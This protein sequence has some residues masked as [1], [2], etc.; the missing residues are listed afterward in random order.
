MTNRQGFLSAGTGRRCTN[1]PA[2]IAHGSWGAQKHE[3]AEGIDIDLWVTALALSDTA[4]TALLLDVDV[5][6]LTGEAATRLRSAVSAATG[7]PVAN[8]RASATH[9]H[10]GPVPYKSWIEKGFDL[11]GPWFERLSQLS[12]EAASEAMANLQPAQVRSGRGEC[13]ININRRAHTAEGRPILGK[14]RDGFSDHEV[15]VVKLDAAGGGTIATLVHYACHPTIMGPANRLITPDYPGVVKRVVEEAVGGRCLFL[16]G[17]AGDQGPVQGFQ[18]DVRVYRGLG[19]I[20]GHEAAKVALGLNYLP[21]SETL[22]EVVESGA[23]LG[24]Y[25]EAFPALS[26]LP[27]QVVDREILVPLRGDLP[28]VEA[29]TETLRFWKEKL[30]AARENQ[31]EEA[32]GEATFMA[33]RADL[34]LRLAQDFRGRTD[35]GVNTQFICFGD[36]A[37]VSCNVE[38]FA[39]IG[40]AI[41]SRSPFPVTL[42]SGYSNGRLA[43]LPTAREWAN[44]GYEV[45]NSPFGQGAAHALQREVVETLQGVRAHQTGK[46]R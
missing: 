27:L 1:P 32:I 26:S 21:A 15:L 29:A 6:I 33:R 30:Q 41:K 37:L 35:V 23:P 38:P 9:T 11:V 31:E 8:I 12:A 25:E 14:N 24:M 19:A 20:L 17:A 16:Q 39:E 40:A 22:R 18:A 45:E 36:V 42:F 10:S 13:S 7:V 2:G 44:G 43:Y 5:Q 3:Q 46:S 34:L 28:E 4:T